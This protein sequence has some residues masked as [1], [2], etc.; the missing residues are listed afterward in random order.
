MNFFALLKDFL[1]QFLG[2]FKNLETL[3]VECMRLLR[4]FLTKLGELCGIT[5]PQWALD[6][7]SALVLIVA[8]LVTFLVLFALMSVFERKLLARAQ[9]RYGPNRVGPFGL[10]QPVADGIKMLTKE[11]LVPR[12]ADKVVHYLAPIVM[13][14]PA[15]ML[16]VFLPFGRGMV[17]VDLSVGIL[18][19]FALGAGTELAVFMAGWA[20]NNKYSILGAM[21]AIAQ[22]I[23]Y[24]L[25]LVTSALVVALVAGTLSPTGIAEA[26]SGYFCGF[27]PKW[28]V[29]T[30][31]GFAACVL[32][33]IGALSE[34][35]R[36]PFDLPEGESEIIAGHLT[37]YSGFKYAIF[38]MAEYV[39]MFAVNGLLVTLFLGGYNAPF[40]FLEW[41]PTWCWF[42]IKLWAVA[43]S[44]V[45][46]RTTLPRFR[47]DQMMQFAWK[48]LLPM[49]FVTLLAAAAWY[50]A[51]QG[52][53][54]WMSPAAWSAS[55]LIVLLSYLLL[56]TFCFTR[57]HSAT[58]RRYLFSE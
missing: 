2:L 43:L 31:W 58:N 6:T 54:A 42:F 19:F 28:F 13:V 36:C 38:F 27:L 49:S 39:G 48:F 24:E 34:S 41:V 45:W 52:P 17:A 30:P 15:L 20:S 44:M 21:R 33:Y 32:F 35:N 46:V 9:N 47:I 3:P 55:A 8:I 5:M 25:P 18:A 1:L 12:A 37:E 23:S 22:M 29:C 57:R 56:G 16:P 14:A 10:F 40:P 51:G 7:V 11:D 53:K 26:Q 50:Y 4:E